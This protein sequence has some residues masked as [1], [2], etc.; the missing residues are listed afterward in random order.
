MVARILK[1]T[2]ST[3]ARLGGGGG[4]GVEEEGLQLNSKTRINVHFVHSKEDQVV[5]KYMMITQA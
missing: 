5:V 4:G 1:K 2:P 3:L